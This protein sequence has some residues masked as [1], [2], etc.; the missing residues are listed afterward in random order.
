MQLSELFNPSVEI[1]RPCIVARRDNGVG[2]S[3]K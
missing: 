2:R 1:N 3:Q